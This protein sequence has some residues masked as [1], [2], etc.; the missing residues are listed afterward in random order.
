RLTA[1]GDEFDP[2]IYATYLTARDLYEKGGKVNTSAAIAL[3]RSV[4]AQS[5]EFAAA[6]V[7][8]AKALLFL[9]AATPLD[10]SEALSHSAMA[11]RLRPDLPDAHAAEG[12]VLSVAGEVAASNERF[13][14]ALDLEPEAHETLYLLG[15]ACMAFQALA[16]GAVILERAAQ[17]RQNDY[18]AAVLS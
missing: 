12:M 1:A 2:A 14:R 11:L 6:H 13:S 16:P 7:G 3:L 18:Y 17:L 5:P 9:D 10:I 8:L 4:L 15:R